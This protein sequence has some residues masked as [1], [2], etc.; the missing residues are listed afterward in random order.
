MKTLLACEF[1]FNTGHVYMD[2]SFSCAKGF[3]WGPL[4][5][6]QVKQAV[7]RKNRYSKGEKLFQMQF[8]TRQ[9]VNKR[10]R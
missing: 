4:M 7:N 5:Q 1:P 2:L 6:L 3:H 10:Q 9:R 8:E